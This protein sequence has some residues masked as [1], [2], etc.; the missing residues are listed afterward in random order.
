MKKN[1]L[2][3]S[4]L[5]GLGTISMEASA[6]EVPAALTAK[7][8]SLKV[9]AVQITIPQAIEQ[10]INE[11][12]T[13]SKTYDSDASKSDIT[14]GKK[15]DEKGCDP[16]LAAAIYNGDKIN[17]QLKD[18]VKDM[19]TAISDLE[20]AVDAFIEA[21]SKAKSDQAQVEATITYVNSIKPT[22]IDELPCLCK[23]E[24]KSLKKVTGWIDKATGSATKFVLKNNEYPNGIQINS[25]VGTWGKGTLA[26]PSYTPDKHTEEAWVDTTANEVVCLQHKGKS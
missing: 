3:L 2:A 20:K 1:I 22:I 11:A 19:N 13:T 14:L 16:Y 4:L 18:N 5:I 15:M 8:N 17:D 9:G 25:N 7:L 6:V 23:K 10:Y 21:Q 12:K 24:P 26:I